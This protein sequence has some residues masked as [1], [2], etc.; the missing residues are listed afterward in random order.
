MSPS[1]AIV[2]G[3]TSANKGAYSNIIGVSE[4]DFNKRLVRTFPKDWDVYYHNPDIVGYRSRSISTSNLINR[5]DYDLVLCLHFNASSNPQANG[6]EALYYYRNENGKR[7]AFRFGELMQQRLGI[8]NRG[9][10]PLSSS[11]QRG[12]WMIY[13]PR[14]TTLILEPFFGTSVKDCNKID[15]IK[16]KDVIKQLVDE[17][18]D[19]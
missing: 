17:Y 10:K 8:K 14:A 13:L 4:W 15:A 12:Y 3:H 5:K 6:A 2:V 11:D 18:F 19:T 16:Y 9:G 1:V 7:L